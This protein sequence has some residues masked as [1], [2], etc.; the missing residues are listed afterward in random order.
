M[1][2]GGAPV[3]GGADGFGGTW[4]VGLLAMLGIGLVTAVDQAGG[5]FEAGAGS[6][7]P[8][9]FIGSVVAAETFGRG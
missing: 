4:A 1:A 3:R 2:E 8:E 7:C 9:V 6:N 5:R